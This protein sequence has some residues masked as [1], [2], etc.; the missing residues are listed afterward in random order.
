MRRFV[1]GIALLFLAACAL[2]VVLHATREVYAF[3]AGV[4]LVSVIV[5]CV[6]ALIGYVQWCDETRRYYE[7]GGIRNMEARHAHRMAEI[8]RQQQR[9]WSA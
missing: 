2:W 4:V 8:R 1:F 7:D 6:E 9:N 3:A 5:G